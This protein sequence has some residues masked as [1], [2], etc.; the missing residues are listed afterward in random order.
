MKYTSLIVSVSLLCLIIAQSMLFAQKQKERDNTSVLPSETQM[1]AAQVIS[2]ISETKNNLETM[3]KYFLQEDQKVFEDYNQELIDLY[4]DKLVLLQKLLEAIRENELE[5][6]QKLENQVDY[7]EHTIAVADIKRDM[8]T[9]IYD[10][11]KR[12]LMFPNDFKIKTAISTLKNA[13][14][15]LIDAQIALYQ[16]EKQLQHVYIKKDKALQLLDLY[17]T[18]AERDQ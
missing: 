15:E 11:E 18:N 8:A 9:V 13:Y 7:V 1:Y 4:E 6:I 17:I 14:R 10:Y 3:Q 5:D 12:T 16:A 2:K